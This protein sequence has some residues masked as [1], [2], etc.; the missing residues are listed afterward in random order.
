MTIKG[1]MHLNNKLIPRLSKVALAVSLT[2][3]VTNVAQAKSWTTD[4]GDWTIQFDSTWT[5]GSSWRLEDRDMRLVGIA[6]GGSAFSTNGDDGN[7]NFDKGDAFSRVFKGLHE[8]GVSYQDTYGVFTRF[9]YFYDTELVDERRPFKQ[10]AE[11]SI[12]QAGKDVQLLDAFAYGSWDLGGHYLQVRLGKQVINWGESTFIQHGIAEANP[13]NLS[14]LRAPGSELKEAFI[15]LQALWA[16]FDITDNVSLEGYVQFDWAPFR[17]DVPGSYFATNDFVGAGG[18][19]IYLGFGLFPEGAP[20]TVAIRQPDRVA[21]DDGQYGL[22]LSWYAEALNE[23]EFGF[24]YLNY[25]NKRPIISAYAHNGVQVEGFLEYIEDIK[26]YGFSFN[27]LG[28]AGLSIAGEV[29]YRKDEPIQIDDVELLFATLEPVGTIPS[30][31]SQIP[32]G[33]LPGDEISGYRLLDTVQAQMTFTQ[34]LGPTLGSDQ[35]TVLLEVGADWILDMPSQSELRFEAPGT[36]RSGNPA[37]AAFEGVETNPFADDFSWGYRLVGKLDYSDAFYGWNAS[38]RIV[39][40]HDVSGTTPLPI[41]NFVEGRK[42]VAVGLTLD[43]QSRWKI[44]INY[45]QFFGAGTANTLSDR[46]YASISV[47]YSI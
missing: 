22:K 30:G 47:S 37:R 34:L 46:D 17:F 5:I 36:S 23:T 7:L 14:A 11:A 25:H 45:N 24:Y 42:A 18:R 10:L 4:D 6:N 16:S 33:A 13:L 9:R 43:Y 8:L 38:P 35:F 31:T 1:A 27:T 29:S 28:P 26:L 12:N 20:G 39:F 15:P 44:D 32:G 41:G 19:E 21:R 40:Q 2:L 3:G